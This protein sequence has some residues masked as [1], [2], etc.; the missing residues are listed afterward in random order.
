[1]EKE[2]RDSREKKRHREVS[3]GEND[4]EEIMIDRKNTRE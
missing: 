1:M 2:K 4:D 3:R